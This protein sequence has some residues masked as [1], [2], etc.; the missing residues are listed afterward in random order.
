MFSHVIAHIEG[1]DKKTPLAAE[2]MK[3]LL[4]HKQGDCTAYAELSG[5][6]A[7]SAEKDAWLRAKAYWDL[8]ATWLGR[9]EDKEGSR[10]S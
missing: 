6:F 1:R 4:D 2:L 10:E 5:N 3:I 8:Q 7:V 9:E